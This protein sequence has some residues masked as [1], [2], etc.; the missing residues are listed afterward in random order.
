MQRYY[1][2]ITCE[3]S[4]ELALQCITPELGECPPLLKE[5]RSS[6]SLPVNVR[7]LRGLTGET[8][9]KVKLNLS[10]FG[11]TLRV[12]ETF[13]LLLPYCHRSAIWFE[14]NEHHGNTKRIACRIQCLFPLMCISMPIMRERENY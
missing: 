14:H 12:W 10:G 4:N 5:K 7:A 13:C 11:K 1:F 9:S 6:E 2:A 3:E 8:R